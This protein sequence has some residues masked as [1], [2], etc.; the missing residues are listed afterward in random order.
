MENELKKYKTKI[1]ECNKSQSE[2]NLAFKSDLE[3]SIIGW[4]GKKIVGSLFTHWLL[5]RPIKETLEENNFL[6]IITRR[7]LKAKSFR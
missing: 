2:L 6:F 3:E 5:S 1:K 7:K 4:S